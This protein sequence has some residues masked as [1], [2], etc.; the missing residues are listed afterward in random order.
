[1]TNRIAA[2]KHKKK[3]AVWQWREAATRA[4]KRTRGVAL[5]NLPPVVKNSLRAIL[6]PPRFLVR[7]QAPIAATETS[8]HNLLAVKNLMKSQTSLL[9]ALKN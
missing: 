4:N 8:M 6:V 5:V 1:M 7:I 3:I 2:H 9:A